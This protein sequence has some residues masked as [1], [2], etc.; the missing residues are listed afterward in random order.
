MVP[1]AT[2]QDSLNREVPVYWEQAGKGWC[3]EVAC[4]GRQSPDFGVRQTCVPPF[5]KNIIKVK[6]VS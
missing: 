3:R 5:D 4:C 1:L 2:R 6:Y